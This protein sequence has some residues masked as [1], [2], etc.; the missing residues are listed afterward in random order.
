MLGSERTG[1]RMWASYERV[2]LNSNEDL[3]ITSL[4]F[5]LTE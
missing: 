4:I 5:I 3:W 2:I 1:A